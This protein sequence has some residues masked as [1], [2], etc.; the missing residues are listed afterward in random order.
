MN[1]KNKVIITYGLWLLDV[2]TIVVSFV[3]ATYIRFGNFR[4]MGDKQSHF[5]VCLVCVFIATIYA[6]M[7]PWNNG[8]M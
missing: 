4:D 2:I 3:L 8:I 5:M 6:F 7:I 1:S